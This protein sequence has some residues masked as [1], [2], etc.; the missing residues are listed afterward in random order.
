MGHHMP[1]MIAIPFRLRKTSIIYSVHFLIRN[2]LS[3][4]CTLG[5]TLYDI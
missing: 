2:N 5:K 1:S 4:V 3:F